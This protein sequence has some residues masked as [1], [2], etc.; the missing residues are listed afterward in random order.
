MHEGK[1]T[2]GKKMGRQ[3]STAHSTA[4]TSYNTHRKPAISEAVRMRESEGLVLPNSK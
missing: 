1:R 4:E 2:K 3:E